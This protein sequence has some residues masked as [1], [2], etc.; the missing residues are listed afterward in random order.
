MP[1]KTILLGVGNPILSD[2]KAGLLVAGRVKA[3][4]EGA[5]GEIPQWLTIDVSLRGGLEFAEKLAGYERAIVVD[6]IK[7]N[8]G[9]IGEIHQLSEKDFDKTSHLTTIHGINFATAVKLGREV[10]MK[11]PTEIRVFAVEIAKNELVSEEVH[12]DVLRAV[13]ALTSTIVNDLL[14]QAEGE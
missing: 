5:L 9:I 14:H 11:M 13:Q 4:I 10:G 6:T 3:G 1:P 8:E 12:E 7:T 2:D